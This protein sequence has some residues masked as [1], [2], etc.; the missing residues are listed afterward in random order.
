[1]SMSKYL[2][3]SLFSALLLLASCGGWSEDQK[4]QIK[5]KCLGNGGYDCDCYVKTVV[6]KYPEPEDFNKLSQEEQGTVVEGCAV[7]VE[8]TPEEDLESF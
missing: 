2:T 8:E 4:T 3:F 1:M 7:E 5:N 6:E